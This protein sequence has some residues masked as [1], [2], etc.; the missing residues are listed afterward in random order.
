MKFMPLFTFCVAT[1]P[2][3]SEDDIVDLCLENDLLDDYELQEFNI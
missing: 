3:V 1:D 2:D